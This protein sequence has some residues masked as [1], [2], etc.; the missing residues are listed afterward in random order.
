MKYEGTRP[1]KKDP[2]MSVHLFSVG[3]E[4]LLV[5]SQILEN[6]YKWTPNAL[7]GGAVRSRIRAM[8][9]T[10]NLIVRENNPR[11]LE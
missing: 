1:A 2:Q 11:V 9:K 3:K 7:G 5:L 6:G 4:E 10:V 8:M